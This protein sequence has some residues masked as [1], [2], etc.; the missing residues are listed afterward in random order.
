MPIPVPQPP[1]LPHAVAGAPNSPGSS[2]AASPGGG[3]GSAAAATALVKAVMPALHKALGAFEVGSKEYMAVSSATQKLAGVF[4]KP[5]SN[6]LVPA[7]V[8]QMASAAKS[9]AAP[10]SPVAP[11]AAGGIQP[12]G[13][14]PES[15]PV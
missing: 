8:Q 14:Q 6:N 15:E 5:N 2:P 10:M 7:A 9:G 3:A 1:T 11:G 4:A 13:Q 12:P